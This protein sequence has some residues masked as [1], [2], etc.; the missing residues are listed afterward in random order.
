MIIYIIARF[1]GEKCDYF[2]QN[3]RRIA[4]VISACYAENVGRVL[5]FLMMGRRVW[6]I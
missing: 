4:I 6:E 3:V 5:F 2:P 1:C